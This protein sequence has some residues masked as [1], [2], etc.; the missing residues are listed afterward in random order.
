MEVFFSAW[1]SVFRDG[2]QP[3]QS[4]PGMGS[5][6]EK[7]CL[8]QFNE[9]T[10]FVDVSKGSTAGAMENIICLNGSTRSCT[11]ID[12]ESGDH[13]HIE[14]TDARWFFKNIQEI[15]SIGTNNRILE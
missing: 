12:F 2:E 14:I 10:S 13:L 11:E 5:P 9:F 1:R 8:V 15:V 7:D 3:K 6:I 4:I